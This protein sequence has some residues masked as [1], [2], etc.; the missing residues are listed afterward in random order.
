MS[1]EHTDF[2]NA[3][4]MLNFEYW[5]EREKNEGMAKYL[6]VRFRDYSDLFSI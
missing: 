2:Y 5:S 1:I 6:Q 4:C 3:G